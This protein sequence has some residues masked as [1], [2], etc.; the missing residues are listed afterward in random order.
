MRYYLIVLFTT[1]C[2][3]FSCE[4]N[5]SNV[6]YSPNDFIDFYLKNKRNFEVSFEQGDFHVKLGYVPIEYYVAMDLLDGNSSGLSDEKDKYEGFKYFTLNI[7]AYDARLIESLQTIHGN[8]NRNEL[9]QFLHFSLKDVF[10]I[11][12]ND[13]PIPLAYYHLDTNALSLKG[14]DFTIV[15]KDDEN[16]I[17]TELKNNIQFSLDKKL[18]DEEVTVE[19]NSSDINNKPKLTI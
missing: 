10:N 5:Y 12:I 18:L 4:P 17:N 9:L 1:L 2:T 8:K 14:L 19:L 3:C 11:T 13:N 6:D 15:F 16:Y 7:K